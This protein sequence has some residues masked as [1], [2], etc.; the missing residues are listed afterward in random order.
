MNWLSYAGVGFIL[1]LLFIVIFYHYL[2]RK[3][4]WKDYRWA[5]YAGLLLAWVVGWPLLV[6]FGVVTVIA[7][8]FSAIVK[9]LKNRNLIPATIFLVRDS[10]EIDWENPIHTKMHWIPQ[11]GN[12]ILIGK[13]PYEVKQVSI[14][15]LPD[16]YT[17][18]REVVLHL[19]PIRIKGY[20]EKDPTTFDR[21]GQRIL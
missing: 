17:H 2:E 1:G 10:G 12:C 9:T 13:A 19:K 5:Y 6:I 7:G 15:L 8:I 18:L 11:E 21:T 20:E 14:V 4:E 3:H 16:S